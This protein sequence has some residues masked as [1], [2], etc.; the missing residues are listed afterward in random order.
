MKRILSFTVA[1]CMIFA[2]AANLPENSSFEKTSIIASAEVM[3]DGTEG[4]CG[5]NISWTLV[6][7]VLSL[8]GSGDMYDYK[9]ADDSPFATRKDI[10]KIIISNGITSVGKNAFYE[11]HALTS[12]SLPE[13]ITKINDC[14]FYWCNKLG[15]VKIPSTVEI[16]GSY[17]FYMTY[18]FTSVSLPKGL[19]TIADH[20][21]AYSSIKSVDLPDTLTR[22]GEKE[23]EISALPGFL[24][25]FDLEKTIVT[26]DAIGC[27]S[28]VIGA[29][30]EG[31]GKYVL[32]VKEN[33]KKLL[34]A[35]ND[36]IGRLE[37]EGKYY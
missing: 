4:K 14:A 25:M 13:G 2:C 29:I 33:Q 17:S 15:N 24:K 26:I 22:I 20:A 27:N 16:I 9:S 1:V 6:D 34:R 8:N 37:K 19:T 31:G 23:N 28:T 36:E 21:F 35:I 3:K 7:G 10:N 32:P 11:C 30:E 12:V 18:A 5:K